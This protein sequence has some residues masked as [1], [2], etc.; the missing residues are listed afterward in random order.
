MHIEGGVVRPPTDA[1]IAKLHFFPLWPNNCTPPQRCDV[2]RDGKL[3]YQEFKAMIFRSR[4][5]KEALLREQEEQA[6]T[7]QM[8]YLACSNQLTTFL[9]SSSMNILRLQLYVSGQVE[10]EA[11]VSWQE[12]EE[13]AHKQEEGE[14]GE[15]RRQ[16]EEIK[17][18]AP[19]FLYTV[20]GMDGKIRK[21][22]LDKNTN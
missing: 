14:E 16:K 15:K 17:T 1:E 5:R 18:W 20:Q 4:E 19:I 3:D 21:G 2:D 12:E 10:R 9:F 11:K 13:G 6:R 22:Y 7:G 8:Y